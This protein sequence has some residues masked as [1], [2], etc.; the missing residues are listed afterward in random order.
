MSEAKR[1][2]LMNEDLTKEEQEGIVKSDTEEWFEITN[3]YDDYI[4][5]VYRM[6]SELRSAVL[7]RVKADWIKIDDIPHKDKPLA[8]Q[9]LDK[10]NDIS[11]HLI[12]TKS[13]GRNEATIC[14]LNELLK[15]KLETYK[16]KHS[17]V[18]KTVKK[19][20]NKTISGYL[21][22]ISEIN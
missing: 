12:K 10:V 9:L 2:K 18:A 7:G 21:D 15:L 22:F 4:R 14:W 16:L 17:D 20:I 1:E 3:I 13:A 6:R 11:V 8:I 19:K 5:K